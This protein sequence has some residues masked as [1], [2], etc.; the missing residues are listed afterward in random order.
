MNAGNHKG[1]N[2]MLSKMTDE[3]ELLR[4]AY[5]SAENAGRSLAREVEITPA[6][7]RRL[8]EKNENNR[9]VQQNVVNNIARDITEGRWAMNGESIIVADEGFLNDGQH[10]LWAIVEADM[11]VRSIV[12]WG[13]SRDTRITVDT[14]RARTTGELLHMTGVLN[15]TACATIAGHLMRFAAGTMNHKMK[16]PDSKANVI[17][18]YHEHAEEIKRALQG[19][20]ASGFKTFG[21]QSFVG[22]TKVVLARAAGWQACEDFWQQVLVGD[23]LPAGSPTLYLRNRFI[24]EPKI[25]TPQRL[26]LVIRAWNAWRKS[27]TPKTLPVR[28]NVPEVSK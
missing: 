4:R 14:G 16:N 17:E 22:F 2:T 11:P 7:A 20:T 21:G 12:V 25:A 26:E 19:T 9:P 10:R 27:E 1:H 28:G 18:Y 15:A 8:L 5:S 24:Q 6:A 3:V 23:S 13:V